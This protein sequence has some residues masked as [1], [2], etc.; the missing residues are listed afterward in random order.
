MARVVPSVSTGSGGA[1]D[2]TST[3]ALGGI[4]SAGDAVACGDRVPDISTT[5]KIVTR[6]FLITGSSVCLN[7]IRNVNQSSTRTKVAGRRMTW[8]SKSSVQ[9]CPA[10]CGKIRRVTSAMGSGGCLGACRLADLQ[11]GGWGRNEQE[12]PHECAQ[13][14]SHL[15]GCPHL[16]KH[17]KPVGPGVLHLRSPCQRRQNRSQKKPALLDSGRAL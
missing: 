11:R 4:G 7:F 15:A 5:A 2:R 16:R 1:G 10:G 12:D 6:S 13:G 17:V 8:H 3:C 14:L 9:R